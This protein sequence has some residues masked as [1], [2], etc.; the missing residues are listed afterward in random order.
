MAEASGSGPGK[1]GYPAESPQPRVR[2]THLT[3]AH[4]TPGR[5]IIQTPRADE[6]L[7]RP[8]T[9]AW[10]R[11]KDGSDWMS[12]EGTNQYRGLWHLAPPP[13]AARAGSP[14]HILP[15]PNQNPAGVS[16]DCGKTTRLP[17]LSFVF[18]VFVWLFLVGEEGT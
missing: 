6:S 13:R 10:R 15:K 7:R 11:K 12:P 2:G 16:G 14:E 8:A 4:A 17:A 18:V 9:L 1:A 5:T 3:Q